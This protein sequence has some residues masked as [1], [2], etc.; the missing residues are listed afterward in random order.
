V[1]ANAERAARPTAAVSRIIS[2]VV[3]LTYNG[4]HRPL[5]LHLAA[6]ASAA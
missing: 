6:P 3:V 4:L 1:L 5:R 2:D